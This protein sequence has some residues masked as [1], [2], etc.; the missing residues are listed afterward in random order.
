VNVLVV[1]GVFQLFFASLTGWVMYLVTDYPERAKRIGILSVR[2]IRQWHIE[3]LMQGTLITALGAA[4]HDP[5]LWASVLLVVAAW[6]APFGFL[7][8]AVKPAVGERPWYRGIDLCSF[9]GLNVSLL[10]MFLTA[11]SE[12]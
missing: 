6:V 4:L 2:R 3:L 5:P 11:L 9:V 12:R 8:L 10:V 7:V 1:A